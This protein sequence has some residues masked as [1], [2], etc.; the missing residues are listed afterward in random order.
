VQARQA[1]LLSGTQGRFAG[2]WQACAALW[3]WTVVHNPSLTGFI[4][5]LLLDVL[6]WRARGEQYRCATCNEALCA[7]HLLSCRG[8]VKQRRRLANE[9]REAAWRGKHLLVGVDSKR[10]RPI[11]PLH[12]LAE[13][14]VGAQTDIQMVF[15][16][17]DDEA[18][19]VAVRAKGQSREQAVALAN[20]WRAL[21]GEW[22]RTEW[23]EQRAK[24]EADAVARAAESENETDGE[25]D[26]KRPRRGRAR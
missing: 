8:R 10:P 15:G 25:Q 14:G 24:A 18:M 7:E 13:A 1:W 22:W 19:V 9:M 5:L 6:Q 17:W 3:K 4:L 20:T 11:E 12:M 2:S 16:A 23:G 26:G 21:M